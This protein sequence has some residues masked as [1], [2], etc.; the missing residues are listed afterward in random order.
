MRSSI[1][2]VHA[3]DSRD[4]SRPVGARSRRQLGELGADLLERQADPLGEDDERDP[5]Q[6]RARDS[7]GGPSRPA[8][9]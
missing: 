1:R 9:S 3:L 4:Q 7:G 8:R 2:D 6:H 5:P